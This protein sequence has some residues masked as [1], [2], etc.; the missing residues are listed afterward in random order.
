MLSQR[1]MQENSTPMPKVV[2]V[3]PQAMAALFKTQPIKAL[4][5]ATMHTNDAGQTVFRPVLAPLNY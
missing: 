2:K 1:R 5:P 4:V 3:T